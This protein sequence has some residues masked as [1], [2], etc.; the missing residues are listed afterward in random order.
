MKRLLPA[1]IALLALFAP[2]AL[3]TAAPVAAARVEMTGLSSVYNI[4]AG[5]VRD[6]NGD[7]LADSVAARVILPA[8]PTVEDI[9][10]AANIAG[11]LG[12]ETT[13]LSLPIV[14]RAP[15][16]TQPASVAVPIVVGRG[17]PFVA[18]LAERGAIDLKPLKKGQGLLAVVASPLGG[19]DGLVVAGADDEG[20]L[21]AANELAV[22][23][24]RLWGAAG[25]RIGQ[26]E[27][28]VASYLKT[29]GLPASVHGVSAML[30]DSDRRGLAQ[31]T[32]RVD[33]APGDVAKTTKAIEDLDLAHRRGLE[34]E[35]LNYTNTAATL[36]EVWAAGKK[37]GE[38]TVRRSGLNPRTLT[39]PDD[40]P[41]R[42]TPIVVAPSAG[43]RGA[44]GGRGARGAGAEG[45]RGTEGAAAETQTA[46]APE[47]G[48]GRG[49]AGAEPAGE[50]AAAAN[51]PEGVAAG[52][53]GGAAPPASAA[54]TE[55]GGGGGPF[56]AQVTPVPP[57]TFDLANAYSIEGWFGDSY[58]DLLPDRLETAIVVGDARDSFGATHIATRLGLETTGITLPLARDARKVTNAAGEPNPILVGRTNDLVRQLVKIGKARLDDLQAGEGAIQVV[59]RAF[60]A[61]TAT[62]VAGA[63]TGGTDAAAMYLARRT[64]YLWDTTR[65]ALSL[66]DLKE[67]S[68]DF[69]AAKTGG[70][71]ASLALRELD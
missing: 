66:D 36:V 26:A 19:P 51:P 60:G 16:V 29:R 15:E 30:V 41:G 43:A 71:Q 59:P 21:N 24:P 69:F 17:N 64:P 34:P 37:A 14:M 9:Q 32:V 52:P 55:A 7:G 40:E 8:D 28:Q 62:V 57:K 22:N 13:A 67:H 31:L 25:A 2:H 35:T 18:K 54:A 53:G 3:R 49:A 44:E 5:A 46:G 47:G 56:G 10:A 65:G 50:P 11:R 70:A 6:T 68:T 12:F 20:T 23:L 48:R 1:A 63:D 61:G 38:A 4:A 45:A 42:G 27:T 58:V 33:V 39:P